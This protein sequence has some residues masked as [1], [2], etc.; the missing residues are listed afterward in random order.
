MVTMPQGKNKLSKRDEAMS[1]GR[2]VQRELLSV[3]LQLLRSQ[4]YQP[5]LDSSMEKAYEKAIRAR[6]QEDDLKDIKTPEDAKAKGDDWLRFDP[7]YHV[8]LGYLEHAPKV[9]FTPEVRNKVRGFVEDYLK[10]KK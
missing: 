3:M 1:R 8:P 2:V 9:D 6:A 4:K 10:A 7:L 5:L